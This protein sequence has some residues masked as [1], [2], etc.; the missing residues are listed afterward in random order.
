M[1]VVNKILPDM[2][3]VQDDD[4]MLVSLSAGLDVGTVH[5]LLVNTK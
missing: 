2:H 5:Q 3:L 1:F 4:H